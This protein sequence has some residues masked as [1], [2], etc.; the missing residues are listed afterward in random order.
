MSASI[1]LK[2]YF[3]CFKCFKIKIEE[4]KKWKHYE[5][6]KS[7]KLTFFREKKKKKK[8]KKNVYFI[9][10]FGASTQ[11]KVWPALFNFCLR[12][13]FFILYFCRSSSLPSLTLSLKIYTTPSNLDTMTHFGNWWWWPRTRISGENCTRF[14]F[15]Y[16]FIVNY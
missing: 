4:E 15:A 9:S 12:F 13:E 2:F 6:E 11:D 8:I 5:K 3:V 1:P 10:Y 14:Y 7:K 16:F